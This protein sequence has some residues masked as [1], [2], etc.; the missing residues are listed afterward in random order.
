MSTDDLPLK[1]Y[2]AVPVQNSIDKMVLLPFLGLLSGAAQGSQP[3]IP[4]MWL[5]ARSVETVS[6]TTLTIDVLSS[7]GCGKHRQMNECGFAC[8]VCLC[9]CWQN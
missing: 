8:V 7:S 4:K 3:V 6:D 5:K 1:K 9:D 2:M